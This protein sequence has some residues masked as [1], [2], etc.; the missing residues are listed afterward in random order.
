MAHLKPNAMVMMP[1]LVFSCPKLGVVAATEILHVSWIL[2]R[3]LLIKF[4][5]ERIAVM[6]L[7]PVRAFIIQEYVES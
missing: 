3:I 4:L 7:W 1:V 6:G 5:W 2:P